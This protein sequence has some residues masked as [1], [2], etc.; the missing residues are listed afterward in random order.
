MDKKEIAEAIIG[1][2]VDRIGNALTA[3]HHSLLE[4]EAQKP[5]DQNIQNMRATYDKIESFLKA[6]RKVDTSKIESLCRSDKQGLIKYI[7][8][9]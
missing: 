2:V 3:F 6:I 8:L 9:P 7:E 4:L 5:M 1:T